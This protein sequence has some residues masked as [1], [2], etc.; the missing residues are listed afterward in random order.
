MT[1]FTFTFPVGLWALAALAAVVVFYLFYR[2]YR[3]RR[4]TGLF[5]W[6]VPQRGNLGGRKAETPLLSRA[7]LFDILAALFLALSLAGPAWRG[8]GGLPLAIVLDASFA[9]QARDRHHDVQKAAAALAK[10]A[11]GP[12]RGVFV[13][14][15]G[16]TPAL[17][18]GPGPAAGAAAA[19]GGYDPTASSSDLQAAVDLVR[20]AYGLGLDIHV[21]TNREVTLLAGADSLLTTHVYAARGD[22]LA[23]RQVWREPATET[24]TPVAAGTAGET[25]TVALVNHADAA[26]RADLRLDTA[27]DGELLTVAEVSLPPWGKVVTRYTVSGVADKTLRVTL[28]AEGRDVIAADSVAF[29]PPAPKKTITYGLSDLPPAAARFVLVALEAAGAAPWTPADP[30]R[31]ND[32]PDLLIT[33]DPESVGRAA[34]L[35]I[36][37]A[38]QPIVHTPPLIMDTANRLCR[39]VRLGDL[40]WVARDRAGTAAAPARDIAEVIIAAGAQPLYWR[41]ADGRLHLDAVLDASP[42]VFSAAWPVLI[43]NLVSEVASALPG[44]SESVYSPGQ[45]LSYRPDPFAPDRPSYRLL[46]RDADALA[47]PIDPEAGG[48]VPRRAG[49][50]ELQAAGDQPVAEIAVLPLYAAASDVRHA[51]DRDIVFAPANDAAAT[52]G[53]VDLRW[54][55]VLIGLCFLAANWRRAVTRP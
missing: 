14:L 27:A 33:A 7:F 38:G 36:P 39:D 6:G 11:A 51:S 20:D 42:L 31:D 34:T 35:E 47:I 23:F 2:R 9:M 48:A 17:L 54:L 26:T 8:S 52:M 24:D 49:W 3:P 40:P 29:L 41:S 16:E 19:I 55:F 43:A 10:N 37:Q 1:A 12:T 46:S 5:L 18:Y 32:G 53:L 50:Y 25:V 21:F 28:S 45:S 13:A 22:N 4:V 30:P 15:A 44:L